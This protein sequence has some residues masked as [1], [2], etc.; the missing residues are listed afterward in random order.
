MEKPL[1]VFYGHHKCGT[2]WIGSILRTIANELKL[3]YLNVNSP[4]DYHYDIN[5]YIQNY[6]IDFLADNNAEY[7]HVRYL[8][9]VRGFHIIRDPRDICVSAY[10]SHLYSHPTNEK[11]FPALIEFRSKLQS[12]NKDEGLLLDMEF[13]NHVMDQLYSWEYNT[14]DGVLEIKFEE[15]I[16]NPYN[17]IINILE[18]MGILNTDRYSFMKRFS[19]LFFS[20]FRGIE[21]KS[22]GVISISLAPTS[23]PVERTFGIIWQ[24]DFKQKTGGRKRGE[25]NKYSHYR[26]GISGDWRN[27]FK[28]QHIDYF[29]VNYNH[30]LLKLGYEKNSDW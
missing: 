29:K 27:H 24:N 4:V 10:Y 25:T 17:Q 20:A 28:K 22:K 2:Q 18:S 21:R 30:V 8:E 15:L 5:A 6:H 9:E 19:Y 7:K 3:R 26:K 16:K 12:C 23:L 1:L 13:I 14:L 11:T